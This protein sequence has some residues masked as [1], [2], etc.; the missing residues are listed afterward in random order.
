MGIGNL[1][2]DSTLRELGLFLRGR[3]D[4]LIQSADR[5]EDWRTMSSSFLF[6]LRCPLLR[7]V[8]SLAVLMCTERDDG[9]QLQ[10]WTI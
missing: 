10:Q 4:L 5:S 2:Y 8:P 7:S 9:R 1:R 3:R 6:G